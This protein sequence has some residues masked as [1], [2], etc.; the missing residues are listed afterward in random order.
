MRDKSEVENLEKL[1]GQL[2]GLH[3]EITTLAKKSPSD[4]VNAFKLKLINKV[5]LSGN[6]VLGKAYRP[7]EDFEQ[8]DSD[9]VPSTSDVAMVLGQYI[10]EAERF[11][12]DNVTWYGGHWVYALGGSPSAIRSGPP[13]KLGRK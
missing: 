1:I 13:S 3:A 8:F 11:R 2:Q 4:A 7:F 9:D 5:I 6:A 12:S 10:E